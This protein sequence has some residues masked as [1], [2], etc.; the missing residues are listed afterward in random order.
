M[1]RIFT[2]IAGFFFAVAL[3]AQPCTPDAQYTSA[4]I[5]PDTVTN[6]PSA[7]VGVAYTGILTAVV[8]A[9]TTIS[10]FTA[11]IDS[12]VVTEI[13]GL[14]SGFSWATNP[15]T[16]FPGG[17]SGCLAITGTPTAAG[18]YTLLVKVTSYGTI[19]SMPLSLPDTV[20]GYKIIVGSVGLNDNSNFKFGVADMYPNPAAD[21]AN[22]VIT[23]NETSV[24]SINVADL[25]GRIVSASNYKVNVGENTVSLNVA[26]FPVG[27]YFYTV[28]K[29]SN[30]VT[31]KLIINR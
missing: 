15:S 8:P 11:T 3:Y 21:I 13:Q 17:T 25:T 14:P 29:G 24:A 30:S 31:R 28:T 6:L 5:Y 10:G 26:S 16:S 22:F 20:N 9:D 12:I 7:S 4:G 2:L 1:K 27:V 18:T 23:S 19:M